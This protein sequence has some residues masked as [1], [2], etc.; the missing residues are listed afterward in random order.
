MDRRVA[1]QQQPNKLFK[2]QTAGRT[3][4]VVSVFSHVACVLAK[5]VCRLADLPNTHMVVAAIALFG[6]H[7]S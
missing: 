2:H 6:V 7:S 4:A 1:V 3:L 5:L